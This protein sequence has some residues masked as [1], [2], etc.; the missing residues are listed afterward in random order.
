MSLVACSAA[1]LAADEPVAGGDPV[2]GKA[3]YSHEC[4]GSHAANDTVVGPKQCGV[5][6]RRAGAV[7][8]YPY[9]DVMKQAGF[10]WDAKHLD[11]F[12]KSPISYFNGTNMGYVGLDSDK[13]RTDV[14]AYL[15]EEM[16]PAVCVLSTAKAVPN[17]PANTKQGRR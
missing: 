14:I 17:S 8:G 9:S 5:F 4:S 12:L 7:P 2:H 10:V 15:R 16:D 11:D 3:I 13:D 6:G 1:S